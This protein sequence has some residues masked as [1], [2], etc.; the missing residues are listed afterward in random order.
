LGTAATLALGSAVR[1]AGDQRGAQAAGD[2]LVR[3]YQAA[4]TPE[5]RTKYLSALGNAGSERGLESIRAALS[6]PLPEIRAAAV[7]ALRFIPSP[8]ADTL[9][10]NVLLKDVAPLVRASAIDAAIYRSASAT[11]LEA[12]SSA[13]VAEKEWNL[14]ARIV[15]ALAQKLRETPALRSVLQAVAKNDPSQQVRDAASKALQS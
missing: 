1:H 7:N 11:L 14:R 13:V 15:D 2:D 3:S 8:E 10:A 5:Q 9:M 4:R 6:D 12:L